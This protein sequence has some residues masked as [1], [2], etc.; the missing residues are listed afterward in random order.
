MTDS[1]HKEY[2][3]RDIGMIYRLDIDRKYCPLEDCEDSGRIEF[4]L[5]VEYKLIE[6]QLVE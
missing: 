1:F 5:E 6:Y 2:F 4:G 3:A